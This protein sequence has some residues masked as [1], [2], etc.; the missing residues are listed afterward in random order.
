M[1]YV[2]NI[3][4]TNVIRSC[5]A[6]IKLKQSDKKINLHLNVAVMSGA[7]K[8]KEEIDHSLKGASSC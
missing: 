4:A 8:F 2:D 6:D 7:Y 3:L 5:I 1:D